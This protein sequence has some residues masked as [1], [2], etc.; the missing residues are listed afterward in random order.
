MPYMEPIRKSGLCESSPTERFLLVQ[1]NLASNLV[2]GKD[3][4]LCYFP[5]P[6]I[7]GQID[8]ISLRISNSCQPSRLV[9]VSGRNLL[10]DEY[11]GVGPH[12]GILIKAYMLSKSG[13]YSFD[14]ACLDKSGK[15]ISTAS[16]PGVSFA[17][18]I[19]YWMNNWIPNGLAI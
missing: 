18:D 6:A 15:T 8:S 10:R 9:N 16:L 12:V 11:P 19:D 14:L 2:S 17:H 3:F 7:F 5:D 13:S 4:L 1:E